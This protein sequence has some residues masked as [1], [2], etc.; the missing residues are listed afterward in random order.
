MPR[1]LFYQHTSLIKTYIYMHNDRHAIIL[2]YSVSYFRQIDPSGCTL[3]FLS[4]FLGRQGCSPLFLFFIGRKGVDHIRGYTFPFPTEPRGSLPPPQASTPLHFCL[5]S[6]VFMNWS[7]CLVDRTCFWDWPAQF[8]LSHAQLPPSLLYLL[9]CLSWMNTCL[10][11]N[12]LSYL[13][14]TPSPT[15]ME[16]NKPRLPHQKE[17]Q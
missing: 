14:P 7:G 9:T 11:P 3:P 6:K 5:A 13:V 15:W 12:Q 17:I 16:W 2:I 1:D 10:L 4:S 8:P